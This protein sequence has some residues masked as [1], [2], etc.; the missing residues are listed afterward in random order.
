AGASGPPAGDS[1][2]QHSTGLGHP[3]HVTPWVLQDGRTLS[4]A[5]ATKGGFP[6]QLWVLLEL[7]GSELVLELEQNWELVLGTGTLLFYLPNG[8]RVTQETSE[9]EHCCYRGAARG[10]PGSWA[11]LCA[12]AGLSGHIQLSDTQ[13]YKLEPDTSS[14]LGWHLAYRLREARLPP[15]AC[16]QEP[17]QAEAEE[18]EPPWPRRGKR[19][20]PEQRFV[21]L[22]MVVDHRAVS[23]G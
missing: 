18:T 9:Q 4:L 13:S 23:P 1:S 10:V 14:T 22:V 7:E 15:R 12:C 3:W 16:G 17:P 21:E 19:A 11:S 20:P 2:Q 8:T 6:T 5:E